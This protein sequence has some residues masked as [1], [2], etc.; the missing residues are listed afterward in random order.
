[1]P[2]R[3]ERHQPLTRS[4]DIVSQY[5]A[6]PDR[7]ADRAFYKAA[8]WRNFRAD[9]LLRRPICERCLAAGLSVAGEHV[10]HIKER[11]DFPELAFVEDN[12]EVL[13]APCH[14]RETMTRTRSRRSNG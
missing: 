2:Y 1:M 3:P 8:R 9:I 14:S 7:R 6:M 5:E 12:T 11:K 13:C 10:H 4:R